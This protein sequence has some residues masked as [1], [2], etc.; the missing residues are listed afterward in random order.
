MARRRKLPETDAD[1]AARRSLKPL[2]ALRP[3]ALAYKGKLAGAFVALVVA[4][5][6]T[7]A[8]PIAVRR[9]VDFGLLAD[10]TGMVNSYFAAVLAVVTVLALASACRYWFVTTLG[11]RVVADLRK[12][13]F[14][15]LTTLTPAF[16]DASRAGELI[17]RLTADTTQIKSA[18]G[19]AASQALRNLFMFVG[20]AIMMAVS[21]PKLFSLV[22][23]A[24]PVIVLPLVAFGRSV[25]RRSRTAQDTLA[26]A[27]ALAGEALG[28]M[29]G[30]QAFNG[31]R[32]ITRR[33]SALVEGSY[34]AAAQAINAR[35]ILTGVGIFLVFASV[36]AVLWWGANDVLAGRMTPGTLGQFVLYAVFAAAAIGELSNVWGEISQ[37]AGSA[38]RLQELLDTKAAV[39]EPVSPKS[40]P[41]PALG[42]LAFENVSFSYHADPLSRTL[43]RITLSVAPGETVAIVGPSGGGKST[44]F[45]LALRFYDPQAGRVTIDGVD[46]RETSVAEAR[47]RVALVP[48]D[49]V[50]FAATVRDN[51]RLG[52]EDASDAEVEAAARLAGADRFVAS[53]PQGYETPVGERGVTLSGGQRQRVALARALLR[54]ASVLLL[55]EAT[56]ALDA[57]SETLVQEALAT[58]RRGRTTLVIAHRLA[59]VLAA[60]RIVVVDAGRIVEE[61]TH[62]ELVARRGLYA[63]LAELQ[64][65]PAGETPRRLGAV[66]G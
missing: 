12:A 56:S 61:G 26:G 18:F 53:L 44:L 51:I 65:G 46:L 48:Q 29:R 52:R 4:A 21:S 2:A 1:A 63:R 58:T 24:I 35:A 14:A 25:R 22:I 39:P 3:Y 31:E 13:V 17:S 57:E 30:V 54:D 23:V 49:P 64:F 19:V 37:A 59:T 45:H 40:L 47:S 34:E 11:E 41:R 43:D 15:H 16:Y 33:F 20:A 7:L 62:A 42:A 55:D 27:S 36:V 28:A 9:L 66:L 5:G 50:V 6:A 32:A 10:H 38:E 60:D 8:I